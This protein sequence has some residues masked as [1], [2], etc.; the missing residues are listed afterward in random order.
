[1]IRQ[2]GENGVLLDWNKDVA[3]LVCKLVIRS[4]QTE[5]GE[6]LD[7]LEVWGAV[8]TV[9]GSRTGMHTL[10]A[11]QATPSFEWNSIV[12]QESGFAISRLLV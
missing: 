8:A 2:E 12:R 5:T 9:W 4:L 3:R 7:I 1:M 10:I 11:I 6:T